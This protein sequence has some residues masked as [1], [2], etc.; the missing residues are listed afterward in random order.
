MNKLNAVFHV[1]LVG[2]T[3]E[4]AQFASASVTAKAKHTPNVYILAKKS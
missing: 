4:A 3:G 2:L 1:S